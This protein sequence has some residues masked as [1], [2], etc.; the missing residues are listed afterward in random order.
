[1]GINQHRITATQFKWLISI[2]SLEICLYCVVLS[3]I[4]YMTYY[5]LMKERYSKQNHLTFFYVFAY[6][7][8]VLR[9]IFFSLKIVDYYDHL[10]HPGYPTD[11][12]AYDRGFALFA[13][14][15]KVLLGLT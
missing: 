7:V 5:L 8:V 6:F 12:W 2:V 15:F 9:I 4:I 3:M 13:M 1:M 14:Y 10:E 11:N